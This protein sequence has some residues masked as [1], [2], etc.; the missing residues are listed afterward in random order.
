MG[1]IEELRHI[2][3][4]IEKKVGTQDKEK[5]E[6]AILQ[7]YYSC[8]RQ[9][10]DE[11]LDLMENLK[12]PEVALQPQGLVF[13]REGKIGAF[14]YNKEDGKE[15]LTPS[16]LGLKGMARIAELYP[17]ADMQQIY[18]KGLPASLKQAIYDLKQHVG[19]RAKLSIGAWMTA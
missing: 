1:L 6:R 13:V 3:A 5:Y 9:V 17:H 8:F 19:L 2:D 10:I 4:E 14:Y 18:G 7:E 12:I 11:V 16:R 15:E